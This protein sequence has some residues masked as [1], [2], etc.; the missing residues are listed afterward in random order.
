MIL[1]SAADHAAFG[2]AA[3]M[4]RG[5]VLVVTPADLSRAGW[6]YRPGDGAS[7]LVADGAVV[8][9]DRIAGVVTRLPWV[10]ESELP[11]IVAADRAYVAAEMHAFLVAWLSD[12]DC[13][14]ANRPG[15]TCLCGPFW[16]H[17]RWV[18]AAAAAGL[19]V[20]PARRAVGAD[21]AEPSP[22]HSQRLTRVV[23]VG[24]HC[25][26]DV[27]AALVTR[28]RTLVRATGVITLTVHFGDDGTGARF[29]T[30]NPWPCLEQED[31]ACALL[32]HLHDGRRPTKARP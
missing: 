23:M 17:E 29:I 30:A 26:G 24:E 25:V 2:F 15:P 14:V 11:H 1:A 21:L 19:A 12:L 27:D 8:D 28:A 16:R 32:D 13:P 22:L 6:C 7:M 9:S 3:R 31:A 18:V 10:A 5:A 20:H 4:P